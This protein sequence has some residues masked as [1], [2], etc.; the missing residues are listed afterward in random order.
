L[1]DENNDGIPDGQDSDSDGLMDGYEMG[2]VD[3]DGTALS[4]AKIAIMDLEQPG[5]MPVSVASL[6]NSVKSTSKMNSY[7]SYL[8]YIS[9]PNKDD[10]DRDGYKDKIDAEPKVSYISPIFLLHGVWSNVYNVFGVKSYF[11]DGSKDPENDDA[12]S[13]NSKYYDIGKQEIKRTIK[14]SFAEELRD[15]YGT[16]NIF[17]F[18][19]A[20]NGDFYK[21]SWSLNKY[22]NALFDTKL[23]KSPTIG[24]TPEVTV[25]AHSM[26][27]LVT[28]SY[29]ELPNDSDSELF[30]S[31]KPRIK[32]KKLITLATPHWGGSGKAY[33]ASFSKF[34]S[35]ALPMLEPNHCI[36]EGCSKWSAPQGDI[37]EDYGHGVSFKENINSSENKTKYYSIIG[38]AIKHARK[39]RDLIGVYL[40]ISILMYLYSVG[41]RN[42]DP[43]M[44]LKHQ[45]TRRTI[46]SIYITMRI[47]TLISMVSVQGMM[48]L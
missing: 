3:R 12:D 44:S 23:I 29:I 7:N 45:S 20:N 16:A 22:F 33:A 14:G 35:D 28:R 43:T 10:Y 19:Y 41:R 18:N 40:L 17:A 38:G 47:L 27:G 13:T 36:Y 6:S 21:S 30:E 9:H 46:S 8:D 1:E 4:A 37:D 15:K 31:D 39:K 26:G 32:V 24:G 25:V 48:V 11:A 5:D 42:Q 34:A 2:Y